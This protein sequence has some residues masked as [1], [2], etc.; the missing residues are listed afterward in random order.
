MVLRESGLTSIGCLVTRTSDQPTKEAKQMTAV[1]T[2]AGLGR[3]KARCLE[4]T[5]PHPPRLAPDVRLLPHPAQHFQ[6]RLGLR[7]VTRGA[8]SLEVC[9]AV[10]IRRVFEP[11]AKLDVVNL[12]FTWME[13]FVTDCAYRSVSEKYFFSDIHSS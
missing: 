12:H 1:V 11:S 5:F 10:C 6:I 8:E 4:G 3:D 2:D 13:C 7:S 9:Q